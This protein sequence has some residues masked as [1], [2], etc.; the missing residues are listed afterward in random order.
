MINNANDIIQGVPS[1]SDAQPVKDQLTGEARALRAW[2]YFQLAR[3]YQFAYAKDPNAPGVPI[4]LV[5]AGG[6]TVGNPRGTLKDV[7]TLITRDLEY[8]ASVM[9]STRVDK[10]RFNKNVVQGV[11]LKYI[12]KW[13]WQIQPCG[14]KL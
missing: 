1:I 3:I 10:Y 9:T 13:Q 2:A 5:P 12:R 14:R 4:Y 8:A 7:Y 6:S 11:L